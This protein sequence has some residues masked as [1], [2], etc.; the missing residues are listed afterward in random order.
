MRSPMDIGPAKVRRRFT[1][2]S[3]YL[4]G[5]IYLTTKAQRT[6]LDNFFDTTTQ[7]GTLEFDMADPA[8]G[9]TE[10]F[11]FLGPPEYD[12]Q[13]GD[14]ANGT[15]QTRVTLRLERLP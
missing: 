3:R 11:R 1:A 5:T 9:A 14:D 13:F 10:V 8:D 4:T 12:H 2:T 15:K 6:T 7:G